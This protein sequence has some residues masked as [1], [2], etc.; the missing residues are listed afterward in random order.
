MP[1]FTGNLK[2]WMS[3]CQSLKIFSMLVEVEM[4][5]ETGQIELDQKYM[6]LALA[7]AR[8][9]QGRTS[10]NPCVG[11]IIVGDGSVV[12]RGYH[13]KAGTPHAE[14][15]ALRD[16]GE[17]AAGATA[18]VTL[19]PCSHTGRTPPCCVALAKAGVL[20]V[21][22]GMTDPNPLVNGRGVQYLRDHGIEVSTGICEADCREIN[23]PFIKKIT[24]GT[25]WMIM[26]AGISLDGRMNYKEGEPGWI[27]GPESGALVHQLRDSVDAI[28]VG[29]GTVMIDN[30]SL[31]T[32]LPGGGGRDPV[33]VIL[34]SQLKTDPDAHVYSAASGRS[35]LVF[36]QHDVDEG[37]K[38]VFAERGVIVLPVSSLP[39][40][41]DLGEIVA[42]LGERDI[43][44]VLVEGGAQLHG[45]L[46]QK[47]LY[48][49]L[50]LFQAPLFAGDGGVSLVTGCPLAGREDAI[51]LRGV[52]RSVLGAH[53]LLEGE[54]EYP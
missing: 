51:A 15:H 16:A 20:R 31:T 47:R 49:Y 17:K 23:R 38:E 34:D 9:G 43:C 50:Y 10:P 40:G 42:V 27:T 24:T 28:M 39:E 32:R 1:L 37:R 53:L 35:V 19:E 26:K 12:G 22:V 36:C 4:I 33:A 3:L 30:P 14:V 45:Q 52:R 8:R 29:S 7:E 54:I 6:L 46:L 5:N 2:M 21:V 13:K 18:Y 48:D 11:A 41:L 44:S 25:P